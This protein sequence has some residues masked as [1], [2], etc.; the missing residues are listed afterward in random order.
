MPGPPVVLVR[1]LPGV[2]SRWGAPA[3]FPADDKMSVGSAGAKRWPAAPGQCGR[4]V[5][6]R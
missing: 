5:A 4:C 3:G 6:T 2:Q 1:S